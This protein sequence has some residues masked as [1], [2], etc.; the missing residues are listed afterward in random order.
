MPTL[1]WQEETN[2]FVTL[3][4]AQDTEG[5]FEATVSCTLCFTDREVEDRPLRYR[6]R[7]F[8]VERE[9]DLDLLHVNYQRPDG[10][11]VFQTLSRADFD[12]GDAARD[13]LWELT[14]RDPDG[15]WVV[16]VPEDG[17]D[18]VIS[19]TKRINWDKLPHEGSSLPLCAWLSVQPYYPAISEYSPE[20]TFAAP[21]AD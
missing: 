19:I 14:D 8:L 16:N 12:T 20:G 15:H 3:K 4:I 6:V 1:A 7:V 10:N 2:D 17:E 13:E 5:H 9:R 21:L 18:Q 11:D